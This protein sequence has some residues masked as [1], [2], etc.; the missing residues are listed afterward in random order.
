[1]PFCVIREL[2]G[3]GR[4]GQQSHGTLLSGS[5]LT[6][7]SATS[8]RLHLPAAGV[9]AR[10]AVIIARGR[11]LSLK[12]YSPRGVAVNGIKVRKAALR[13]GDELQLGAAIVTI[14]QPQGAKLFVLSVLEPVPQEA[15]RG[16][17]RA[18]REAGGSAM[19]RWSWSL[20]IAVTVVCLLIPLA[21]VMVPPVGAVLRSTALLP[22]D[23]LWN[24]GPLHPAH[25]SIGVHCEACHKI[26]FVQVRDAEC[27]V[28]HA[29]VQAHVDV[30]SPDLHL[31]AGE[32]CTQ[33][34]REHK[35]PAA[36]VQTD[37]RLCTDCHAHLERLKADPGV[38][39]VTDFASDH[40]EFRLTVLVSG[41]GKDWH[42]VRLDRSQP[43]TFI[44]HSHLRFSHKQHLNPKGIKTPTGQRVLICQDCHRPDASGRE[45][46]PITMTSVCSECHSLRFDEQDPDSALPHGNL[47][48]AIQ[49]VKEHFSREYLERGLPSVPGSSGLRRPGGSEL[50]QPGGNESAMAWVDQ[51]TV[52]VARELMEKRICV[53]CHEVVHIPGKTGVDQWRI[54]PVR[55][56]RDWMPFARFDH[57]AHATQKCTS[58]HT[59]AERSEHATDILIPSIAKCRECHGG[60]KDTSK[61]AS[62]C[63]MCH[64]FHLPGRGRM[65]RPSA[66][67]VRST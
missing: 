42:P 25:Q 24:P 59:T 32:R 12:V 8:Q 2:P 21:G 61:V 54:R 33:C 31:F 17:A 40:P 35:R 30:R 5:R 7:G 53:E 48:A 1:M 56:T 67:T 58:C 57:A 18:A 62:P 63:L 11:R 65:F 23:V 51:Q 6:V 9:D 45:M 47:N 28:C 14:E 10:H 60:A 15:A 19:S 38:R 34:H 16:A 27:G 50:A 39:D 44:E 13:P 29:A 55:L 49:A 3:Q 41:T 43:A 46:V 64:L 4:G 37:V 52:R 22:S 20:T 36:L 26:P 66:S